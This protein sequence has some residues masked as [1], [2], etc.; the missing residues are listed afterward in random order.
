MLQKLIVIGEAAARLPRAFTEQHPEIP[1]PDIVAFRNIAVH[2]YFAVDWHIV[3]VTAAQEVPLLRQ[4]IVALLEK[5]GPMGNEHPT[6]S[7][8]N[9]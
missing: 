3:W 9:G 5:S 4:Q 8:A 2:E 6:P 1:W 7:P